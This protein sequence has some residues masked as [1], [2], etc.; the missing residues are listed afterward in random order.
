MIS[1]FSGLCQRI[2][3]EADKISEPNYFSIGSVDHDYLPGMQ[4][5]DDG[6]DDIY[7]EGN[8]IQVP[9]LSENFVTYLE[10]CEDGTVNGETY[11][12]SMNG[13][14]ISVTVFRNYGQ[15]SI[16]IGGQ[17]GADGDPGLIDQKEYETGGW[18]GFVKKMLGN[19]STLKFLRSIGLPL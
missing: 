8:Y 7:D 2:V 17:L 6:G 16:G 9:A 5:I 15:E 18:R 14:G 19:R 3:D 10:N 12:M 11:S 1:C 13:A 4:F